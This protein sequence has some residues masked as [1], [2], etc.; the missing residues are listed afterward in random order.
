MPSRFW[1]RS[2]IH[3]LKAET[4]SERENKFVLST[5]KIHRQFHDIFMKTCLIHA[6]WILLVGG[7]ADLLSDSLSRTLVPQTRLVMQ[8]AHK[9]AEGL[10]YSEIYRESHRGEKKGEQSR[11][12]ETPSCPASQGPLTRAFLLH[13]GHAPGCF[14]S[15]S[16]LPR[17]QCR[18]E[19]RWLLLA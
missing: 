6:F 16:A 8:A 7:A 13:E 18:E 10:G 14:F 19:T 1:K 11:A 15:A 3:V 17:E 5:L 9:E 4:T 2:K 12:E